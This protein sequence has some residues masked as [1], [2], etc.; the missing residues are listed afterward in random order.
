MTSSQ[1]EADMKEVKRRRILDLYGK[2]TLNAPEGLSEAE[3][4]AWIRDETDKWFEEKERLLSH[5]EDEYKERRKAYMDIVNRKS[6][7]ADVPVSQRLMLN[8]VSMEELKKEL[9]KAY[10]SLV[11]LRGRKLIVDDYVKD[12]VTNVAKWMTSGRRKEGLMII[13]NVGVGKTT[14]MNAIKAVY[15][16]RVGVV[17]KVYSAVEL[18]QIATSDDPYDFVRLKRYPVIGI[19][20]LGTESET[21]KVYGNE[22]NPFVELINARY[23]AGLMTIIT[24]NLDEQEITEKYGMRTYDRLRESCNMYQSDSRQQSYR[25]QSRY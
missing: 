6:M 1:Y 15:F 7:K 3:R 8:N 25:A 4:D 21:H 11:N 17:M 24:T 5:K 19:D 9:G 12:N 22:V 23:N 10:T 2:P 14:L 20:D 16:D 13:G 18:T